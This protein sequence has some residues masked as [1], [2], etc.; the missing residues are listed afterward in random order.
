MIHRATLRKR[1]CCICRRWFQPDPRVGRRQRTCGNEQCQRELHR[2][3]CCRWHLENPDYDR[4]T[5]L[6][7][8]LKRGKETGPYADPTQGLNWQVARDEIGLQALVVIDEYAKV[9]QI[10][11]RDEIH[12]QGIVSK[13]KSRRLTNNMPRDEMECDRG[14]P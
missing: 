8:R 2:K 6:R 13:G 3:N 14:P 9:T 4:E 5:R 7:D 1:P 12:L 10:M 11:V